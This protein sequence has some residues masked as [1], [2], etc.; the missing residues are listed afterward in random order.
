MIYEDMLGFFSELFLYIDRYTHRDTTCLKCTAQKK[1][2]EKS[3]TTNAHRGFVSQFPQG[4]A[5]LI[6]HKKPRVQKSYFTPVILPVIFCK[7][8]LLSLRDVTV[9]KE[10][11]SLKVYC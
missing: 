8:T 4:K 5:A 1:G 3:T 10:I 11:I 2:G 9:G 7:T 6:H